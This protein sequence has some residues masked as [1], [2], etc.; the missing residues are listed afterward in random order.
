MTRYDNALD[1]AARAHSGQIRKG[2]E[3]ALGLAVP[4]ITHPVAV[5][6]L[7]VRYG[8]D[9]DQA[10]AALLHDVL[11][12][13]GSQWATPIREQFGERVLAMVE[14]CT[15]GVPDATG[16]KPPWKSR[17]EAYLAHLAS[18][19][20]E[21]LLVSACDKLHNLQAIVADVQEIGDKVFERFTASKEET[22]W[23][24]GELLDVLGP[25]IEKPL[26]IALVRAYTRLNR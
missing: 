19:T 5:S 14:A 20:D 21:A 25:R 4:Y 13:G 6:A 9:E 17:K 11:E 3:N 23:Y 8:G 26:G 15:D 24:Y 16:Q 1:L 10:I 12:D 22:L 18:A 7:V 2:T